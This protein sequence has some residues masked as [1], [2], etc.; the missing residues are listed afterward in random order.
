MTLSRDFGLV[1][2]V[3]TRPS[4][5]R[6]EL[7]LDDAWMRRTSEQ[8]ARTH[9]KR[10]GRDWIRA[11]AIKAQADDD[12]WV[13]RL[14]LRPLDD[15]CT[16]FVSTTFLPDSFA[17]IE[18]VANVMR[19]YDRLAKVCGRPFRIVFKGGVMQRILLLEFWHDMPIAARRKAISYLTEH[20]AANVS[21][22]DFEI[23]PNTAARRSTSEKHKML[24][25]QY[26]ML[27]WLQSQLARQLQENKNNI[28][29]TQ[30]DRTT[31][32]AELRADLQR[33][34]DELEASH[35]M[36]GATV[37][38]VVLGGR[39]D[40]PPKGYK[41][42]LGRPTPAPRRNLVVFQCEGEGTCVAPA[43]QVFADLGVSGVPTEVVGNDLYSTC[44]YY[45]NEEA[46]RVRPHELRPLFH[47]TR[48][49]H[50]FVLYYRTKCGEKRC[51][52]LAGE[53]IDLSQSDPADEGGAW[54][55]C[56]LKGEKYR[57]YPIMGVAGAGLRSFTVAHFLIENMQILHYGA[58]PPWEVPKFTKRLLRYINF[59]IIHVFSA[60]VPGT[61]EHK[62][63]ALRALVEYTRTPLD[64][65]LRT[66]CAPVDALAAIEQRSYT[67]GARK[68][69]HVLH[70]HLRTLVELAAVPPAWESHTIIRN[71]IWHTDHI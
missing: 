61:R 10:P 25:L 4:L 36:H 63:R 20:Q 43:T 71:H 1:K 48:I 13:S 24:A 35:P 12:T 18:L 50:T 31:G 5:T 39:V 53:L 32:E 23:L 14:D 47:L 8:M 3:G 7:P 52:R 42:R 30:W 41:T 46:E 22:M 17:R 68:Y 62:L 40:T 15:V 21:D 44:N 9:G 37:D 55:N 54:I 67:R 38:R 16:R 49:K 11:D 33:A 19:L 2:A 59:L 64:T 69:L 45:I 58:V 27:L 56:V 57:N 6:Y 26:A 70:T 60:D 66:G 28:L 29:R 34:V 65:T 51:D